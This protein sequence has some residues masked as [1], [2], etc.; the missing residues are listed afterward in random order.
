MSTR[1][2]YET[3]IGKSQFNGWTA[4]TIIP[5]QKLEDGERVLEI[6]TLKRHHG[7]IATHATAFIH[8]D[9][10]KETIIFQDYSKGV[11]IDNAARA[12]EKTVLEAHEKAL[13]EIQQHI[14][15]AKAQYG[16]A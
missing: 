1:A 14:D 2:T 15:A 7:K 10:S 6:T 11:R 13:L 3:K 16:I 5:L 12:T 8:R 9:I 4:E